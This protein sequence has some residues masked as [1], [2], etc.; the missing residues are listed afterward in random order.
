M[1][2]AF[3]IPCGTGGL[4]TSSKEKVT[5]FLPDLASGESLHLLLRLENT[6]Y[7]VEY[8]TNVFIKVHTDED[9]LFNRG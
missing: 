7:S 3:G 2:H 1:L 5:R 6:V 8:F 4:D 9:E